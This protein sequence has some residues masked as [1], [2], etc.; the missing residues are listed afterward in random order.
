MIEEVE[1]FAAYEE[2]GIALTAGG[3]GKLALMYGRLARQGPVIAVPSADLLATWALSSVTWSAVKCQSVAEWYSPS[4]RSQPSEFTLHADRSADTTAAAL[5]CAGSGLSSCHLRIAYMKH[6]QILLSCFDRYADRFR[7]EGSIQPIASLPYT[8]PKIPTHAVLALCA[9]QQWFDN[10]LEGPGNGPQSQGA[11]PSGFLKP[12]AYPKLLM[13]T[14]Q[15]MST[16]DATD[17]RKPQPRPCQNPVWTRTGLIHAE[18]YYMCV[19]AF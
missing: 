4:I 9:W 15:V 19:G 12:C 7:P 14:T 18:Y 10:R 1:R 16:A 13:V 2:Y 8:V 5:S 6:R 3:Q 17:R 11:V